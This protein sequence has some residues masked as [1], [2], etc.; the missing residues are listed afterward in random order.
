MG[1]Y[2][3]PGSPFWNYRFSLRGTRLSG[4]TKVKK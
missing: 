4:S 1:L 3:Q 2:K